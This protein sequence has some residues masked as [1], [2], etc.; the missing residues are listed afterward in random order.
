M[1]KY[2][3]NVNCSFMWLIP[4]VIGI[5]KNSINNKR[6]TYSLHITPF[7]ELNIGRFGTRGGYNI[8]QYL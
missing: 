8:S 2:N 5:S 1:K 3:G 6:N 7:I 4:L